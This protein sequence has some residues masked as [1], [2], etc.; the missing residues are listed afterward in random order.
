MIEEVVDFSY[1]YEN[2]DKEIDIEIQLSYMTTWANR[3]IFYV[4]KMLVEQVDINKYYS[5]IKKCIDI[6]NFKY[7]QEEQC[8][9]ERDGM[10]FN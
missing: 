9:H 6:L 4:S 7:I 1:I 5:N 3:S 10:A 2:D 8:F